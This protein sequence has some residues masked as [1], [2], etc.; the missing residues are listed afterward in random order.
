MNWDIIVVIII[1]LVYYITLFIDRKT[2]ITQPKDII[3]KFLAIVFLF[4]GVS[5]IYYS[6]TGQPLLADNTQSYNV[7]IFVIGFIAVMWSFPFLM[8]EYRFFNRIFIRNEQE[9]KLKRNNKKKKK[10]HNTFK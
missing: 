10:V 3:M 9:I 6:I 5:L 2:I 4:A 8:K 1:F 7:Y